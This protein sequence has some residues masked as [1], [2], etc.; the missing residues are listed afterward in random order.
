MCTHECVS[1]HASRTHK[2]KTG[3]EVKERQKA[4]L[5]LE[6]EAA[7]CFRIYACLCDSA[8][9]CVR[10]HAAIVP[11]SDN[12]KYRSGAASAEGQVEACEA[13]PPLRRGRL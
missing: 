6:L 9:A 4:S 5:C 3:L 10:M 7:L 2:R 12:Q 13:E 8:R 11:P 1:V